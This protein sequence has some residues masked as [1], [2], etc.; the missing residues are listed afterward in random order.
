MTLSEPGA[1]LPLSAPRQ[2][3]KREV[4]DP[5]PESEIVTIPENIFIADVND[6][7]ANAEEYLGKTLRYSG[8]YAEEFLP[9]INRTLSY[10]YRYGPGC[11]SNDGNVGF[12]IVYD[13]GEY[14]NPDDWVEVTG[15][16]EEYAEEG[17]N[18]LRLRV[19]GI[20]IPEAAAWRPW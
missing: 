18:F 10:V 14:P 5:A 15:I 4:P 12:E 2:Q 13:G 6:I 11:C 19:C 9:D 3:V 20:E 7:Y 16:I 17:I 1:A 8:V